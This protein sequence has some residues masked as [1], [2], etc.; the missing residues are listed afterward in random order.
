MQDLFFNNQVGLLILRIGI[1]LI[2][3]GYG[4]EKLVS[5]PKM[6]HWLGNQMAI[7]GITCM[8]LFWGFLAMLAELGGG[9]FLLFGYKTRCAATAILAVMSVAIIML[10]SNKEPWGK[11]AY[12]LS[13]WIVMASI[14][15]SGAGV[16]SADALFARM[17][18]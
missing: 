11:I 13:L 5:G 2:F 12:P 15:A 16:Y 14:I 3:I 1:G 17:F 8:P 18:C 4:A 9:V 10:W 6:W 7:V